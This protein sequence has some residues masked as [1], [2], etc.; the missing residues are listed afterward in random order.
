MAN[1][2]VRLDEDSFR[3]MI[4]RYQNNALLF[5]E[6]IL[7]RKWDT[8]QQEVLKASTTDRRISRTAGHGVGKS[9]V[10]GAIGLHR[11]CTLPEA[12]TVM[13]SVNFPQLMSRLF[14]TVQKLANGSRIPNWFTY[15]SD[16]IRIRGLQSN[17]IKAQPWNRTNSES[18]AGLHVK[19]PALIADES[20]GIGDE[21]FE[22]F[23]GSMQHDNSFMFMIGNPLYRHGALWDSANRKRAMYNYD[24]ISCLDSMYTSRQWIE[25]TKAA[26]GEDSDNYRTRV[27]GQFPKSESDGFIPEALIRSAIN[28][29][30]AFVANE[31]KIGGLDVARYGKDCSVLI[32]RQGGKM[33][34]KKVWRQMDADD[35]AIQ[36]AEVCRENGVDILCVDA[37]GLGGPV[38]DRLR[39]LLPNR[40]LDVTVNGNGD[41]QYHDR[42]TILWGKT[43]EWLRYGSIPKDEDL[44]SAGASLIFTY[45]N[46][47]RQWLERKELASKRGVHSP[48]EWDALAYTFAAN[49]MP[50][51]SSGTTINNNPKDRRTEVIIPW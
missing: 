34:L 49:V 45:D 37:H 22:A 24:S 23:E 50:K 39:K 36:C 4:E 8:W 41:K 15:T 44:I 35:M 17:W 20:S 27:L 30:I 9:W 32:I 19:S 38:A 6:E 16:T 48:D 51:P 2:L 13:T 25:E 31:P 42:R 7:L 26:D 33:L 11:L 21:V 47:G 12:Q 46:E 1:E 10:A 3:F 18:F 5:A 29:E 14:P 28:R 43:K 40:V